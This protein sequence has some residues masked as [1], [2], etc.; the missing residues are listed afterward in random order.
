MA[1]DASGFSNSHDS[2]LDCRHEE[3]ILD[4][5][6]GTEV[7]I[8]CGLVRDSNRH[9][10]QFAAA[11]DPSRIWIQSRADGKS[12]YVSAI[13]AN[14]RDICANNC[15]PHC[16]QE[17]AS[18]LVYDNDR[19]E[20]KPQLPRSPMLAAAYA[21]YRG[22]IFHEVPKSIQRV[23]SMCFVGERELYAAVSGLTGMHIDPLKPSDLS[24]SIFESLGITTYKDQRAI[25]EFANAF[26]DGSNCNS[27]PQAV[28]AVYI[29]FFVNGIGEMAE[30]VK[31]NVSQD[32]FLGVTMTTIATSCNV[33]VSCL[34]RLVQK[35][36]TATAAAAKMKPSS[37]NGLEKCFM[38]RERESPSDEKINV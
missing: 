31:C 38:Y 10:G 3:V 16:I 14:I 1:L 25:N 29:Y 21:L 9:A 34:R 19:D 37:S 18:Q 15:I 33:S 22:F 13:C 7:C 5:R 17:Y 8:C 4:D 27:P 36:H 12:V 11:S 20:T 28:L 26:Y 6:E 24:L 32:K 2:Y 35:M 30:V 23:A